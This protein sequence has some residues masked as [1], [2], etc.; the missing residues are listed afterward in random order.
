MQLQDMCKKKS[1]WWGNKGPSYDVVVSSRIRLARNLP[2]IPFPYKATL[3]QQK[4]VLEKIKTAVNKCKCVKDSR[5]IYI[6]Q[7]DSIDLQLLKERHLISYEYPQKGSYRGIIIDEG[8]VVN[9]MINEEDH[10][11]LQVIYSG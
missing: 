9:I 7:L 5:T 8:E 1:K 6:S 2:L 3:I 11:R 4:K 10:L